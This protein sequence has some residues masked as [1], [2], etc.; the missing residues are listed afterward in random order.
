MHGLASDEGNVAYCTLNSFGSAKPEALLPYMQ[1]QSLRVPGI[2]TTD[3][4]A[5]YRLTLVVTYK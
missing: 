5:I 2:D 3:T 1:G 4:T